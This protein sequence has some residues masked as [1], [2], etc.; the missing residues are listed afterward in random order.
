MKKFLI[1]A[2][3]LVLIAPTLALPDIYDQLR[4]KQMVGDKGAPWYADNAINYFGTGKDAALSYNSV[5][6]KVYLNDTPVYLEEAVT[7]GAGF[8]GGAI[9]GTTGYFSSTLGAAGTSGFNYTTVTDLRA[10]DD[11]YA[12]HL[13]ALLTNLNA[14]TVTT[15]YASSN[16]NVAGTSAL[17]VTTATSV[18]ATGAVQGADGRFTDDFLVDDDAYVDGTATLN[19]AVVNTTLDV[20][21][22]TTAENITLTQNKRLTFNTAGT[23]YIQWLTSGNYMTIKGNPQFDDGYTWSGTAS[24]S[25]ASDLV[26]IGGASD[27]DY[28]LSSGITR[29]GTG[30]VSLNGN[31]AVTGTKTFMVNDGA[32][33]FG[34]SV[35]AASGVINGT[36]DV[37]G[38]TT[39]AAITVDSGSII[40]ADQYKRRTVTTATNYTI[41]DGG[42]DVY[43]VGN[44]TGVNTQTILFPTAADNVGRV[45]TIIVATDP[46]ANTVILDGENSETIDTSTTKT[47][48]DAVGSMYH[49]ICNGYAWVKIASLGSWS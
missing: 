18:T 36:L 47:T 20:N 4:G 17:N 3:L 35:T 48:T 30:A 49:L 28:A 19:D 2:L 5:M 13:M 31:T 10:S 23:G 40:T 37:N 27:I 16:V 8:S 15:L 22:A 39:T 44:G 29:T 1:I 11:I 7:L 6:D 45:I 46:L 12:A 26:A 42:A 34:S 33:T 24:P 9:S 25:S 43:L 14:T 41:L 32:A 21:G 38:A